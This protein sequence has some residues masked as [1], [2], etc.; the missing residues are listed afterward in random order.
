MNS[1]QFLTVLQNLTS[2]NNQLRQSAEISFNAFKAN[3]L[4]DL[5][6][7]FL[8]TLLMDDIPHDLLLLVCILLVITSFIID[9]QSCCEY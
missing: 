3:A 1:Q 7:M 2:A 9:F 4:P 6:C 5:L 8:E